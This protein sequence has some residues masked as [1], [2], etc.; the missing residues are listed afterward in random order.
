MVG[1]QNKDSTGISRPYFDE[2]VKKLLAGRKPAE[3]FYFSLA[4]ETSQF[5]RLNASKVRQL[6]RVE[7]ADLEITLVLEA[8]A[9]GLKKAIRSV[10]LTGLLWQDFEEASLALERLRAEAPQLPV[11]PY[12]QKPQN[13]G[14]LT[15]DVSGKCLPFDEAV[16]AILTPEVTALDLA[17]IYASGPIT[18]AMANSAGQSLWF[19]TENFSLDYSLYTSTQ[20]ALK[21]T[22]AGSEWDSAVYAKEI[23]TA[24]ARLSVL[25][26][27]AR[28]VERGVYRAYLGPS[29]IE[30]LLGMFSW[31]ALSESSIRQGASAFRLLRSGERSLSPL[32]TLTEDFSGGAVPR[33][34][35]LGEISPEK[36]LLIE[37]GKLK[38]SLVSARSALEFGIPS[39]GA[40]GE[41]S[42]RSLALEAGT[43]DEADILKAL[44]TGLYLSNLHYLNW[45][46]QPGGR[47]T[48]MTR[49]ACFWV[50]NGEVI[51]P[52]ENMRWDDSL[53]SLF[54]TELEALTRSRRVLPNIHSYAHREL[55][56]MLAPG[57]LVGKMHFTI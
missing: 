16:S 48:G 6:G 54:G 26:R 56:G 22:Y 46:D 57:A 37:Q 17:G 33:F 47:V 19:R 28:R 50:E 30:D 53:F 12:A 55:G 1:P 25:E 41:E 42:P 24:A 11:D 7:D 23:R 29:A 3:H 39:N 31:G 34:N 14:N 21:G 32:F 45:S 18:R 51:A 38:N 2:L 9:G 15:S 27:P 40:S 20:R 13:F 43:L 5:L 4:A 44:G 8:P 49:Y 10:S 36:I 52:I 35:S